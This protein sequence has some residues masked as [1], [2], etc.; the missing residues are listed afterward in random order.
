MNVKNEVQEKCVDIGA[1]ATQECTRSRRAASL[2]GFNADGETSN[3]YQVLMNFIL[4]PNPEAKP[5][6]EVK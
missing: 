2:T 4:R 5:T 3:G 1:R 6:R